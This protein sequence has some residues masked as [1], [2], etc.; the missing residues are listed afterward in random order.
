M[1]E[2][3]FK[4][5]RIFKSMVHENAVVET[6]ITSE[7]A[8]SYEHVFYNCV[9]NCVNWRFRDGGVGRC[10]GLTKRV[11]YGIAATTE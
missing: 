2:Y 11:I 1:L 8:N 4:N 7:L 3:G 5:G 6:E 10:W 9:Y